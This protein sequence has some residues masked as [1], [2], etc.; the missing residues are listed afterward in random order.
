MY[1]DWQMV[2]IGSCRANVRSCHTRLYLLA[3]IIRLKTFFKCD[4]FPAVVLGVYWIANFN[5]FR[6][7]AYANKLS[8]MGGLFGI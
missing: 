3:G 7:Q 5:S 4:I 1:Y 2:V 8:T 6:G